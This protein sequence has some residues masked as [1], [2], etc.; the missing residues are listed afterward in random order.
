MGL[1]LYLTH[2]YHGKDG[3]RGQARAGSE[4]SSS[5]SRV[6]GVDQIYCYR[7][8]GHLA[9]RPS[10]LWNRNCDHHVARPA[11]HSRR[12]RSPLG[13]CPWSTKGVV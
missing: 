8:G 10:E 3:G 5:G 7:Q 13:T 11:S 6:G 9:P 1:F 2:H 4:G 12:R